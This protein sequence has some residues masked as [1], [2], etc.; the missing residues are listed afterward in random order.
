MNATF[1]RGSLGNI[2]EI[3]IGSQAR[4]IMHVFDVLTLNLV[5]SGNVL[6]AEVCLYTCKKTYATLPC[7]RFIIATFADRV[8]DSV[9]SVRIIS[10]E[11]A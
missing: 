7:T 10:Y 11:R 3:G 5:N 9:I 4:H 6:C 2:V 1:Y 8:H